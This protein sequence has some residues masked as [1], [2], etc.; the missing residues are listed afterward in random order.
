[1][2]NPLVIIAPPDHPLAQEKNIPLK[3]LEQEVFL[4]RERGSG[5]RS[6]MERFFEEHNIKIQTGMEIGSNEAIKQSVEAGLGLGLLSRYTLDMELALNKL[7]VLDV[8][9]FPIVRH[10]YVMHRRGKRLSV[11]AEAFKDFLLNESPTVLQ[12]KRLTPAT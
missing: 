11:V 6:A 2:E 3:R 5:T 8:A 1:M 4:V 10:W 12:K 9:D 7:V